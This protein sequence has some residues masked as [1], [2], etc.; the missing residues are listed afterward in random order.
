MEILYFYHNEVIAEIEQN[1]RNEYLNTAKKLNNSD[2]DLL[3]IE[4]EYGICGGTHEEYTL[5]LVNNLKIPVATTLHTI[6]K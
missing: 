4:Q 5:D 3:V 6:V 2:I 1:E